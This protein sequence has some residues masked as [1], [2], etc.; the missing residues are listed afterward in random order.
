[1]NYE[2]QYKIKVF[3]FLS[4]RNLI[5]I[6]VSVML[7]KLGTQQNGASP[8]FMTRAA[9]IMDVVGLNMFILV[10]WLEYQISKNRC[11]G[12]CQKI[13]SGGFFGSWVEFLIKT[14]IIVNMFISKSIQILNQF[15]LITTVVPEMIVK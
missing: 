4:K 1:M 3:V 2:T 7:I 11:D 10:H 12:L 9:V 14:R 15:E 13:F 6:Q 5:V 8:S